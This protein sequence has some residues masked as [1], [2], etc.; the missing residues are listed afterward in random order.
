MGCVC[1]ATIRDLLRALLAAQIP[2]IKLPTLASATLELS[3][4]A[5]GLGAARMA[6]SGSLSVLARL[7]LPALPL[8]SV[9]LAQLASVAPTLALARQA[10]GVNVLAPNASAQLALAFDSINLLQ[11][12]PLPS[13]PVGP[14]LQVSGLVSMVMSIRATFGIDLLAPGAGVQLQAALNAMASLSLP[15]IPAPVAQISM[16]A[17]IAAALGIDLAGPNAAA[18]LSAALSMLA[19]LR[20]PKLT[21]PL[22]PLAELLALLAALANIQAGLGVNPL[23]FG[24]SAAIS[25]RLAP[26]GALSPSLPLSLG[27]TAAAGAA[28]SSASA[29]MAL[30]M[31]LVPSLALALRLPA[32]ALPL[33]DLGP[34]ALAAQLALGTG[35]HASSPCSSCPFSLR[36]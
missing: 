1:A 31:R 21:I 13:V 7:N 4:M 35:A 11:I 22:L 24:A 16:V 34:L 29:L 9:K 10:F 6:A 3:S 8:P 28:A 26:L 23:G 15:T 18:R 36:L 32:L 30:D 12:P 2:P 17:A 25:A 19:T 20:L 14:L 5:G 27:A 33:P